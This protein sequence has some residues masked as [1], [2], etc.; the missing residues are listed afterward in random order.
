MEVTNCIDTI[1]STY[2]KQIND[3]YRKSI[4]KLELIYCRTQI[5]ETV[6]NKRWPHVKNMQNQENPDLISG[7][8]YEEYLTNLRSKKLNSFRIK[9]KG[10]EKQKKPLTIW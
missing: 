10:L 4:K 2:Q 1:L 6:A 3:R 5:E 8:E 7:Y 9:I